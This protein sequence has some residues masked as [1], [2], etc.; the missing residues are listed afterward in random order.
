MRVLVTGGNGGLGRD[1]VERLKH[2]G[3]EVVIGTRTPRNGDEVRFSLS[4]EVS[5]LRGIDTVVHLASQPRD[6]ELE[7]S[8]A[9]A[10]FDAAASEGV[11]HIVYMS[12]VGIDDH[13]FPY[14]RAKVGVERALVGSGVPWT[15][16]SATAMRLS[17]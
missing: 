5:D 3:H 12:I 11:R 1:V 9:K 6:A 15:G 13:P 8:G 7:I 17:D 16:R 10:L 4:G 14:Y 2:R